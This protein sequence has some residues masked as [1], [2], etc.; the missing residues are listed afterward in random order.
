[1]GNTGPDSHLLLDV[2]LD[3]YP[4][5]ELNRRY[6]GILQIVNLWFSDIR[7]GFTPWYYI[8]MAGGAGGEIPGKHRRKDRALRPLNLD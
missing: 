2:F 3:L 6:G 1:M 5:D 8:Y 7:M 4:D